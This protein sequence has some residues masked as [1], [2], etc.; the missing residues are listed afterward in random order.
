MY[1]FSTIKQ[2]RDVFSTGATINFYLKKTGNT[3]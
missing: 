2:D 1:V 3:V